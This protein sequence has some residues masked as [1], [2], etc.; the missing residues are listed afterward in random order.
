M[1]ST[2]PGVPM[3]ALT[4]T[5]TVKLRKSVIQKL[6]MKGCKVISKLPDR[7]NIRY[8][9]KPM[10]TVMVMLQPIIEDIQNNKSNASRRIIFCRSYSDTNEVF[11]ALVLALVDCDSLYTCSVSEASVLSIEDRAKY[12]LVD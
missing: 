9:V 10:P 7:P 1:H 2:L 12:R 8:S 11:Q 5:A 4:A 3:M 6:A